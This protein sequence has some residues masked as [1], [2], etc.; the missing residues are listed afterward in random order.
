LPDDVDTIVE[1][2]EDLDESFEKSA[3][4]TAAEP[5]YDEYG[6]G[7]ALIG[8]AQGLEPD[9]P[10]CHTRMVMRIH[11]IFVGE[12]QAMEG[13]GRSLWDFPDAP[14]TFKMKVA[15]QVWDEARHV[16]L[17]EKV[18]DHVGGE[19]GMFAEDTFLFQCA[20]AEDPVMRV[21]GVNMG[22][23]GLA[24]DVFRD[25]IRYARAVGDPTM[26]QAVDYALAD[27]I[28][29][30]RFGTEWIKKLTENDPEKR[31]E[32][33]DFR[34]QVDRMFS[35]G[36]ARSARPDAPI[37][38]AWE[39]RRQAGFSEEELEDLAN[40]AT[41]GVSSE[42]LNAAVVILRENHHARNEAEKEAQA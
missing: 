35:F 12:L 26:E 25:M 18:L 32:T 15:R 11:A 3:R 23:E 30:V 10:L 20:C 41:E 40:M 19:P 22:I 4:G 2:F 6:P 13:A 33:R 1:I 16:Q 31:Q 5:L 36:G 24:C 37:A 34:R 14:W 9:D 8:L 28:T 38:I 42:T 39:D 7:F 21:T 27:E 29:H 17:F